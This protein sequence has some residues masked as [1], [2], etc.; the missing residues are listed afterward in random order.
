MVITVQLPHCFATEQV[1]CFPISLIKKFSTKL[2]LLCSTEYYFATTWAMLCTF[3]FNSC[4]NAYPRTK[5][6]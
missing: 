1:L 2:T 3:N 4:F 5:V 6:T